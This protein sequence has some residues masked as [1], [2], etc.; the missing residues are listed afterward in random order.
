MPFSRLREGFG[1]MSDRSQR[2]VESIENGLNLTKSWMVCSNERVNDLKHP[3]RV[4]HAMS[5]AVINPL[6]LDEKQSWT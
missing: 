4:K 2:T 5:V 3:K 1:T 6:C